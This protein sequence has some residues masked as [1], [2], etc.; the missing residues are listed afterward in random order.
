MRDLRKQERAAIEAVAR[1]FS[2]TW[3]KSS[4]PPDAYLLVG[5]KRVAV[6]IRILKR[7]AT[8][9]T[10][11]AKPRLRFDKVVTM[12]MGRLQAGLAE[13]VPHGMTVVLTV[14][15]PIR[16][17]A[18]TAT[19]LEDKIRALIAH[20][21]AGQDSKDSIHANQIRIRLLR[22]ESAAAPKMIGFVHNPETDPLLLLNM[23]RELLVL[24]GAASGKT[25]AK[26]AGDQWLIAIS[27]EPSSCLET[28]RYI[29]S[30]LDLATRYR[31]ILIV[32]GDGRVGVLT[33]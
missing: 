3:E 9:Q 33:A 25:A 18:K 24:L 1:R 22:H 23:T 29:Y 31:Q 19:A 13:V 7:T 6:D 11:A 4:D 16:L 10:N 30:Q 17:A 2:A 21:A 20:G 8:S 5:E 15:A 28:C 14:T 32:F 27:A 26:P 12:L